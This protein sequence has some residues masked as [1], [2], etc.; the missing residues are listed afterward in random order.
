MTV[1]SRMCSERTNDQMSDAAQ[2]TLSRFPVRNAAPLGINA[3]STAV[4]AVIIGPVPGRSG[5]H[6]T[7]C[8]RR[9]PIAEALL[10]LVGLLSPSDEIRLGDA[11]AALLLEHQ[12]TLLNAAQQ[13]VVAWLTERDAASNQANS[14]GSIGSSRR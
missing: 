2:S 12:A 1:P 6:S 11:A 8:E 3:P 7:R 5:A 10:D 13:T 9:R 14:S 4:P